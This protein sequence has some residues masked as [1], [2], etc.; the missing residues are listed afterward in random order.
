[1]THDAAFCSAN[2]SSDYL[3]PFFPID[4]WLEM[5]ARSVMESLVDLGRG[6]R[7]ACL[8][9]PVVISDQNRLLNE[10]AVPPCRRVGGDRLTFPIWNRLTSDQHVATVWSPQPAESLNIDDRSDGSFLYF[11]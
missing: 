2:D 11:L 1:M 6:E 4:T 8:V 3:S 5:K 10:P 7:I 9:R